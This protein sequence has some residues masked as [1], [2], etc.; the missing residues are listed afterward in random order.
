[1]AVWDMMLGRCGWVVLGCCCVLA[2]GSLVVSS[3]PGYE[4]VGIMAG[5]QEWC[6][7]LLCRSYSVLTTRRTHDWC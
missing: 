5:L 3:V 2:C 1:M 7:H 6:Q 4:R